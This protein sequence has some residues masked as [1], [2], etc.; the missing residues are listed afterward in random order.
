MALMGTFGYELDPR[1]LTA[2]EK[3]TVKKQVAEYHKY[4]ELIRYGDFT[5]LPPPRRIP[6]SATGNL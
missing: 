6:S 2:Q 3:E 1:K 4:Y 5:A